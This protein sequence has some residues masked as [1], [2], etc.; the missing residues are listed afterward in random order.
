MNRTATAATHP[1]SPIARVV[2]RGLLAKEKCLPPYLFYDEAGSRLFEEITT[3]PEYYPT[4]VERS[5]LVRYADEIVATAAVGGAFPL[6]VIE[7]GAG[8]ATKSEIILRAVVARQ[9]HCVFAPVDVSESAIA[10]ATERLAMALPEVSVR[11]LIMHL[12][13]AYPHIRA[14]G[15]RRLVLFIGSSI[16]NFD[17]DEAHVIL[18]R[19]RRSLA[20][21]GAL[22]LGTDLRKDPSILIPAYDDTRGVTEAFNKNVLARINR[23][24]GG[25]FDLDRFEHVALWNDERSRI[26]MHLESVCE[27]RVAIDALGTEVAFRRG[28]RIHTESSVKYDEARVDA[29]LGRA[30]FVRERTFTDPE[31]LFAVHLA[32]VPAR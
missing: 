1:T 17:D 7:L 3:L 16:G 23:E 28:E 2:A 29:M 10:E 27:Q 5:I 20:P 15:P 25:H 11:P 13:D 19:V 32:R 8:T 6:H 12:D 30:G 14:I 9:G 24:L 22:L 26:E 31:R 18:E 21:G 4:R